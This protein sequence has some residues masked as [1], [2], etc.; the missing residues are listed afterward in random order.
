MI[1]PWLSVDSSWYSQKD[2]AKD[3]QKS[4]DSLKW[5][6]HVELLE[7]LIKEITQNL[8]PET[9][10]KDFS[11]PVGRVITFTGLLHVVFRRLE[12]KLKE[13]QISGKDMLKKRVVNEQSKWCLHCQC[14]LKNAFG[15]CNNPVPN[16]K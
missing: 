1:T 7:A 14:T 11:Q 10:S 12:S 2:K 13:L 5:K 4:S 16:T 3:L 15:Q 8:S 6:I 9:S